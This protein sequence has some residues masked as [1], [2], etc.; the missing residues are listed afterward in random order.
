MRTNEIFYF[1]VNT[2]ATMLMLAEFCRLK[3]L[4]NRILIP[5]LRKRL[6]KGTLSHETGA[7]VTVTHP[8]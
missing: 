7:T 3:L 8:T 1:V 5:T 6:S 4:K 2:I